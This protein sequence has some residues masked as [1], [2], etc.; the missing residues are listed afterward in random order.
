M[1]TMLALVTFA[2]IAAASPLV[3]ASAAEYEVK[4]LN[5]GPDGQMW[6]FS[7]AFLKI[8]PGDTVT[9]TPAD[10]GHNTETS[11]EIIPEGAE[12]WKGKLNEPVTVTYDQEGVY[13]YRCL[14]HA[15][16]G[17]VGIIQVGDSTDNLDA[18]MGAKVPGKGKTRLAELVAQVG[19]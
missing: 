10:K 17:M 8:Q 15:G 12:P 13:A 16:L 6:E 2:A 19:S 1:K 14:P 18:V 7:P 4:M 3:S 5:K 11:P 9:F